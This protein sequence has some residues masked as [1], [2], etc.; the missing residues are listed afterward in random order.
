MCSSHHRNNIGVGDTVGVEMRYRGVLLNEEA[1]ENGEPEIRLPIRPVFCHECGREMPIAYCF[2]DE[3]Y[4]P[5]EVLE[6][7]FRCFLCKECVKAYAEEPEEGFPPNMPLI[8]RDNVSKLLDEIFATH[9]V[10]NISELNEVLNPTDD[11]EPLILKLAN[12][13]TELYDILDDM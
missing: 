2:S 11:N 1:V 10:D 4:V 13:L 3:G 5:D 6:E 12:T 7:I 9:N 8:A